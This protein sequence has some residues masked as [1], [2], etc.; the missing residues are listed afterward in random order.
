MGNEERKYV[1]NARKIT[2]DNGGHVL[3]GSLSLENLKAHV[4]EKGYVRITIAELRKP[5]NFGNTHSIYI[6][7][8]KPKVK[9]GADAHSSSEPVPPVDEGDIPF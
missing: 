6:N 5:D 7:E 9:D 4:S 1:G 2:F 3:N 8:Y